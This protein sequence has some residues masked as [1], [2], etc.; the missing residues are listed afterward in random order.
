[1]LVEPKP[2]AEDHDCDSGWFPVWKTKEGDGDADHSYQHQPAV[3]KVVPCTPR[4][5]PLYHVASRGTEKSFA[6]RKNSLVIIVGWL[7]TVFCLACFHGCRGLE[8]SENSVVFT[9]SQYV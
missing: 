7:R 5:V 9:V 2:E 3:P 4:A 1:M 6:Q 8:G